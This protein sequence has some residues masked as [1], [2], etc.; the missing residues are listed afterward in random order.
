MTD[1]NVPRRTG[2]PPQ[3]VKERFM[4]Y[5]RTSESGCWMWTGS[6]NKWGYG[7]FIYEGKKMNAHRV[8]Y[9]LY[10]G[11]IPEGLQVG[12]ACHDK[13]P[14][15]AGGI[16]CQHRR[17]VNPAHL[18]PQTCQQNVQAS[19]IA[20]SA[21]EFCSQGHPYNEENTQWVVVD[22]RRWRHCGECNRIRSRENHE[23][24]MAALG[25]QVVHKTDDL[26]THCKY[27]HPLT[28]DN[29]ENAGEGKIRC[30]KCQR[31]TQ[32]RSYER[33]RALRQ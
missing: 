17:C 21:K 7:S 3:P 8:S 20:N 6:I 5:V 29:V 24:K 15:C 31:E 28:P 10:K 11:E 12:H 18:E 19:R 1:T 23:K 13:A 16:S 2:R 32:R 27:G 33:R 9:I 26:R 30:I 14:E 22:G 4:K 25:K